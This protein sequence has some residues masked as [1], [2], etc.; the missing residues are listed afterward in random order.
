MPVEARFDI[1][2]PVSPLSYAANL[3][4][5]SISMAVQ[6]YLP[7]E[8][9]QGS[10]QRRS[11]LLRPGQLAVDECTP[12]LQC[13]PSCTYGTTADLP[14]SHGGTHKSLIATGIDTVSTIP[15]VVAIHKDAN[16]HLRSPKHRHSA[17]VTDRAI[18]LSASADIVSAFTNSAPL[19]RPMY[20]MH[21]ANLPA[22]L[23]PYQ[24]AIDCLSQLGQFAAPHM[25]LRV[26]S[27]ELKR[28]LNNRIL[29][30]ACA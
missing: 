2:R 29:D 13:A 17:I 8:D 9:Y 28:G 18:A 11:E 7:L 10:G 25:K 3:R 5:L 21:C 1:A 24:P 27:G 30:S 6:L 22:A 23:V 16:L 19:A 15:A 20:S 14:A 26:I 12:L 4:A